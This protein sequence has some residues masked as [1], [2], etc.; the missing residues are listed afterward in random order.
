MFYQSTDF[1]YEKDP[2]FTK[3]ISI[4]NLIHSKFNSS[5][6]NLS[7]IQLIKQ[8]I[9]TSDAYKFINILSTCTCCFRHQQNRLSTLEPNSTSTS[10]N[11]LELI[12]KGI[13]KENDSCQCCCQC[14]HFIRWLNRAYSS[15]Y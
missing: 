4:H 1:V 5:Y 13:Y 9:T 14:R 7:F 8:Y 10:T 11:K 12:Y 6:N 15:N 2:D 3:L